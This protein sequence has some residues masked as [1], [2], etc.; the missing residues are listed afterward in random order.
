MDWIKQNVVL[1][2]AVLIVVV[3][4]LTLGVCWITNKEH[5]Q[6]GG[7]PAS[8]RDAHTSALLDRVKRK[9]DGITIVDLSLED[10]LA[11]GV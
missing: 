1:Y 11:S 7:I 4:I 9:K 3:I 5:L 10:Q 8:F 2:S 6:Q